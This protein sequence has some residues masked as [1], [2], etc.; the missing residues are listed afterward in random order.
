MEV[1]FLKFSL[2]NMLRT[3]EGNLLL[4]II[5]VTGHNQRFGVCSS[6]CFEISLFSAIQTNLLVKFNELE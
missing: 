3:F 6:V 1:I 2:P 5:L 4:R